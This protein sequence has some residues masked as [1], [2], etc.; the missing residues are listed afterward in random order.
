RTAMNRH[1]QDFRR[2]PRL[3]PRELRNLLAATEP[4]SNNKCVLIG[5][6]DLGNQHSLAA[7]DGYRVM[8]L[9]KAEATGHPAAA[10]IEYAEIEAQRFKNPLLGL[11]R[12]DGLVVTVAMHN[13]VALH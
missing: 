7:R 11:H 12:H 3:L 6:A 13:R 5:F 1:S 4:V 2:V 8:L 10:G 9:L